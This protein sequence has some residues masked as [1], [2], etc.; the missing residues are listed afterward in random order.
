MKQLLEKAVNRYL[1]LDPE[2]SRRMTALQDKIVTIEIKGTPLTVQMIFN[3]G[4]IQLKWDDFS[5]ADL[6]VRGTPLNLAHM[7]IARDQRHSFFA[8]D[9]VLEGDM[10]L[11]QE[12]L[13]FFDELEIDWEE[14]CSKWVGDIPAHQIGNIWRH[15]KRVGKKVRTTFASHL[16]EYVHEEADL[17]PPVE[18]LQDFFHDIDT[19]RM[20][21]DRLEA[22]FSEMEKA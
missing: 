10:E 20:D 11:A 2:S 8:E 7:S 5:Q 22:K 3:Q 13:T 4:K 16:N 14:Y 17:F 9:V 1:A 6:T 15:V 19:L 12:V 18:A 21:V